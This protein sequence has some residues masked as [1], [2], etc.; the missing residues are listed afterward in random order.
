VLSGG[1]VEHFVPATR[2]RTHLLRLL[3]DVLGAVPR[4][5][6]ARLG[7]AARFLVRTAHRR[8]LVFWISDFEDALDARAF[9]V[10]ARRHELTALALRDPRD[11]ALPSVGW[12]ELE[13][14]ETGD[15]VLLNT[16]DRAVRD[17]YTREARERRRAVESVLAK[18][19]CPLLDVRTD[20]SYLPVLMNYFS[21]RA[22]RRAR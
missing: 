18:A 21:S 3:R 1:D 17:A 6:R 10:L 16:R 5:G 15:R 14:L 13:D 4:P 11:D 8:S 12:V 9:R 7:E 2:G 20:R 22:R 19:Q